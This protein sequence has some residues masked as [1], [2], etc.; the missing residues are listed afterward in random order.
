MSPISGS[1]S[2]ETSPQRSIEGPWGANSARSAVRP[3]T[4]S[5]GERVAAAGPCAGLGEGLAQQTAGLGGSCTTDLLKRE[6]DRL[7]DPQFQR[8]CLAAFRE[9]L[10]PCIWGADRGEEQAQD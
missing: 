2:Q 3:L 5:C 8:A 10:I 1:A 7:S 4:F 6:N 9:T